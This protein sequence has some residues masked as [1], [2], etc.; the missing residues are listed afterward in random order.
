MT[1]KELISRIGKFLDRFVAYENKCHKTPDGLHDFCIRPSE[2]FVAYDS[3]GSISGYIHCGPLKQ[4]KVCR[5][6]FRLR[7][8]EEKTLK[9]NRE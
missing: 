1:A 3:F 8:G 5:L 6:V 4:C 9:E 7:E 2:V